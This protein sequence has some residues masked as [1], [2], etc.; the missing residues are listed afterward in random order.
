MIRKAIWDNVPGVVAVAGMIIM[1]SLLDSNSYN[2]DIALF[3]Y[4]FA[5]IVGLLARK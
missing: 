5:F 1:V 4:A 3:G 2:K